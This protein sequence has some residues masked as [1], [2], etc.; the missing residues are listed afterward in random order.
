MN[1]RS[2]R[3]DSGNNLTNRSIDLIIERIRNGELKRGEQ[4]PPQDVMAK[5]LGVSRTALREALKELS[6]RGIIASR[7]G[8]GTFIC[9]RMVAEG[10]TL[11]ARLIMEPEIA[12]LATRRGSERELRDLREMCAVMAKQVEAGDS[13]AFSGHD[14]H[15]HS[16]IAA[17]SHNQALSMLLASVRD[18]MLHQQNVVHVIPGTMERA[19]IFHLEIVE[20]MANRQA[21]AAEMAMRRHLEDVITTLRAW[22]FKG[23]AAAGPKGQP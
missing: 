8:H 3:T 23:T 7:H 17:M 20:A 14:L 11:E 2:A 21:E 6:Y 5:S 10:E 9:D 4:L 18:M 13:L 1:H 22:Q 12:S 19:Y 16:A 15:F